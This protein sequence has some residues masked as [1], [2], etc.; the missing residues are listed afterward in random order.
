M[1]CTYK[2][3]VEKPQEGRDC[4]RDLLGNI[5]LDLEEET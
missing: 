4:F 2:I 5:R 1:R 3:M